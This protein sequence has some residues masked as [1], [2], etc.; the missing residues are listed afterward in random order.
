MTWGAE[1]IRSAAQHYYW[2]AYRYSGRPGHTAL[3]FA[4]DVM[5][6]AG[7]PDSYDGCTWLERWYSGYHEKS[8][9]RYVST[10]PKPK[11]YAAAVKCL[12][13]ANFLPAIAL[14]PHRGKIE[15]AICHAG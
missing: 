14:A 3:T 12:A 1:A 10:Q 4:Y 11:R 6:Q 5:D 13:K 9:G 7:E 15:E 2:R 8:S